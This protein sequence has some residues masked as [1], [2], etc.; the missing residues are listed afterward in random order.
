VGEEAV[1]M[2]VLGMADVVDVMRLGMKTTFKKT[3]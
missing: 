3:G 2:V 1:D